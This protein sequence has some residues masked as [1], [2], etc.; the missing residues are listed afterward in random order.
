V[1]IVAGL[2]VSSATLSACSS[3]GGEG[4]GGSGGTSTVSVGVQNNI[5]DLPLQVADAQGFFKAGGINIKFVSITA[6]TGTPALQSGS[7]NLLH[8]SPT[9]LVAAVG[10]KLPQQAAA[11]D[12]VGNPLGIV[13]STSFAKKHGLTG[14][15]SAA[16]VA[17][18]LKGSTAGV[19]STNT[20]SEAK[21]FLKAQ[22]VDTDNDIKWATLPSPAADQA[23]LKNG[24]I[25]WFIT[26]EPIPYQVE[27]D[28]DGVVVAG[29][30]NV[31]QWAVQSYSEVIVGTK[32]Y[33][34]KNSATMKKFM[35]AVTKANAYIRAHE[36]SA[37]LTKILD[38]AY[39]NVSSTALK[40][41]I[42]EVEW[43][44]SLAMDTP[45]WNTTLGFLKSLGPLPNGGTI[46]DDNWTNDYLP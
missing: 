39:P 24:K 43:P 6:S 15:S 20:E 34:T 11:V 35:S 1:V 38:K 21:V 27:A 25:D 44:A 37:E 23:A 41:S 4:D 30:S 9:T 33:L 42:K 7:I 3:S 28:G 5:Y 40:K 46:T 45:G 31:K 17:Q 2:M 10:K 14:S 36:G 12:A 8:A 16:E 13:V 32:S 22:G 19:S 29:P 26:S 18:A